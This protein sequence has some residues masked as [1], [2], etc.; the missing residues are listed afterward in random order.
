[1]VTL[2]STI[3]KSSYRERINSVLALISSLYILNNLRHFSPAKVY[4]N[5]YNNRKEIRRDH[6]G[7]NSGIYMFINLADS[8]KCY[9]GQSSD[10]A[11]RINN[12]LNNSYLASKNNSNSPITKALQKHGQSG[13]SLVILEYVPISSLDQQETFWISLLNPYYNV[14]SGGAEGSLGFTHS[15]ESKALIRNQRTG[16][17]QSEETKRKIS[18]ANKG[19][20]N[21]F[22][23]K[24]HSR[25][26]LLR[27]SVRKS[28][29]V[30]Y[31]YSNTW[32]LL[33]VV[34]S[35]KKLS[36]FIEANYATIINLI[37]SG[38]MYRGGWYFTRTLVNPE[39]TPKI[40][41]Q[42]SREAKELYKVIINSKDIRKPVFLFDAKSGNFIRRYNGIIECAHDL[43]MSNKTIS[44]LMAVNGKSGNYIFSAHRVINVK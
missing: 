13:F 33:T 43:K 2:F 37:R 30:V 22:F 12:Y 19:S 41:D 29:G 20:N 7:K 6:K 23:G 10:I 14:L 5:F 25:A 39:D 34:T 36:T 31:I 1:F 38:S 32:E 17:S 16:T 35:V 3:L 21:S 8:T 11:G 24:M 27:I 4:P 44:K 26:S 42:D 9:V 18:D 28:L 15:E 40:S